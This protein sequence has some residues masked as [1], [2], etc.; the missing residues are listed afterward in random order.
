M[1]RAQSMP[2]NRCPPTQ[3]MKGKP[4]KTVSFIEAMECLPLVK[5]RDGPE[6]TYEILCGPPHKISYVALKVMLRAD[7]G[8]HIY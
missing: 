4:L 2:I 3:M 7:D 5:V 6:W 1:L 8:L